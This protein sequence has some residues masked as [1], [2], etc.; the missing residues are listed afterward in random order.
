MLE[1][2]NKTRIIVIKINYLKY[3]DLFETISK[4]IRKVY[5]NK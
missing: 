4:I 3:L 1:N 2:A 5:Y